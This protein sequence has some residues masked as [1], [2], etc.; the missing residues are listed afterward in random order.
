MRYVRKNT[1]SHT[2][3][4]YDIANGGPLDGDETAFVGSAKVCTSIALPAL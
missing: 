4:R 2:G 1:S 3:T